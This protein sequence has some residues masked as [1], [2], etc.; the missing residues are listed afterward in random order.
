MR[1]LCQ[2]YTCDMVAQ[3]IRLTPME[4]GTQPSSVHLC[5]LPEPQQLHHLFQS[6][7]KN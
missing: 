2:H 1:F 7:L 4:E 3:T 5:K 6:S